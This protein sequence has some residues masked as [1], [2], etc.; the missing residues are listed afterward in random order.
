MGKL[1]AMSAYNQSVRVTT[2]VPPPCTRVLFSSAVPRSDETGYQVC[3]WTNLP[4]CFSS[5]ETLPLLETVQ[6]LVEI[7]FVINLASVSWWAATLLASVTPWRVIVISSFVILRWALPL[8]NALLHLP[9]LSFQI[10]TGQREE[11]E[12][13]T[14]EADCLAALAQA[15]FISNWTIGDNKLTLL[16]IPPIWLLFF[17]VQSLRRWNTFEKWAPRRL[18]WSIIL[19][20]S[21]RGELTGNFEA[22]VNIVSPTPALPNHPD[23][24]KTMRNAFVR[25]TM[26]VVN[27]PYL[28]Y[29]CL[30]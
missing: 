5:N 29:T 28:L 9:C 26:S 30:A 1:V 21:R 4:A 23:L 10:R 18:P 7:N 20:H 2:S 8:D 11:V 14:R 17:N 13:L 25:Q 12:F 24:C 3:C 22:S 27:I 15:L 16:T 6:Y 19:T